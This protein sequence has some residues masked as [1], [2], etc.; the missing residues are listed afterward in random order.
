MSEYGLV[1]PIFL[2]GLD[3]F[4]MIEVSEKTVKDARRP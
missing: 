1:F 3:E 4:F 2:T